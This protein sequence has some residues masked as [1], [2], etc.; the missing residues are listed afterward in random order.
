MLPADAVVTGYALDIKQ[1]LVEGVLVDRP[2]AKAVYEAAVRRGIDPGLA[3]VDAE[4]T[5]KTR[6]FPVPAK[7]GRTIQVRYVTPLFNSHRG[8][9]VF[10]L[11]LDAAPARWSIN[12]RASGVAA[13]PSLTWAGRGPI[14]MERAGDGFVAR[15]EGTRALQ[16]LLI[17]G[18]PALLDALV[19]RN[20]MGEHFVQLSGAMPAGSA[21]LPSDSVRIY[22]DGSRARLG[23]HRDELELLRRTLAGLNARSIEIEVFNSSGTARHIVTS[24]AAAIE[25]LGKVRYRGAGSFAPLAGQKMPAD[26][27]LLFSDGRPSIDRSV[28]VELPCRVDVVTASRTAD[29]AWLRNLASA[30][31][32]RAYRLGDYLGAVERALIRA[33]PGV[34][35]VL[36]DQGRRLPFVPIESSASQ[37][38]VVARAPERG[39]VRVVIGRNELRRA[40]SAAEPFA[41][42]GVLLAAD[43]LAT[44]GG[45]ERRADYVALSRRY[46][47]ASPSLSFLVLETPQDYVQAD[48]APPSGY[49]KE[50]LGIYQTARQQAD[51]Q[52]TQEKQARLEKIA[53][54]WAEQV[55]WWNRRFEQPRRQQQQGK[56][57]DGEALARAPGVVAP[58]PPPA[59][60]P[61]P[62]PL[63]AM[64]ASEPDS[65]AEEAIVVAGTVRSRSRVQDSPVAVTAITSDDLGALPQ[66]RGNAGARIEI[67]AWQPER[68]YLKAFDA[69]PAR[70]DALF[71]EEEKKHGTLPVFYLDTAAWLYRKKRNPE[72]VEMV[73]AAL[74]LPVANEVTYGLV[75]ARARALRRP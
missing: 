63:P 6:V 4:G 54:M 2:Q 38:L 34:T 10:V 42:E 46:G 20:A 29:L 12:V 1:Q 5:F 52:E 50:D 24:A 36:D 59:M 31:G 25:L 55:A 9:D 57:S 21:A 8:E 35:A 11:P 19:S 65:D 44:L 26:R 18:R 27:C 70:F 53:G 64:E 30:H 3:E 14:A 72:A 43:A 75:A 45:T 41:G 67:D 15:G 40:L 51:D 48:I 60:V 37:W 66:S 33:T 69:A 13:A 73:L 22:W 23:D 62:E 28:K 17:L 61:A 74:D 16:G 39:G 71:A 32:G 68:P 7:G 58:A 49:P 56:R 47:V